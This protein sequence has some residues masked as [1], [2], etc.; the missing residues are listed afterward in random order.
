MEVFFAHLERMLVDIDF[1]KGRAPDIVLRRLRRLFLRARP[2][3][4][5]VRILHGILTEAQRAASRMDK[6]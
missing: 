4:R 6:D 3:Q 2:D 5:E 1:H